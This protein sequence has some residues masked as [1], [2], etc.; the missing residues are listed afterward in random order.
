VTAAGLPLGFG[1]DLDADAKWLDES[2]LFA[3]SP[4]RVLRFSSAGR[5]VAAELMS[6]PVCTP[7]AAS[8][9]RRLTDAGAAHPQPP[10]PAV[11]PDVTVLIPVRDRIPELRRCLA[12]LGRHYPVLVVD[13]GSRDPAAVARV[14]AGH[15]ADLVRHVRNQGPAAARNTGLARIRTEFVA[16]L[17]SDCVAPHGWIEALAAQLADP[18][19]AAAAPR[20]RAIAPPTTSGRYTAACGALD[21]GARPARVAPL[22]RVSYVPTAALLVRRAALVDSTST[23]APFDVQL[24]YGEDV[25][26]VW[27]LHDTGWRVRYDPTVEVGHAEPDS[28]SAL[29]RRRFRYGTSAGALARRHPAAM[30]PLVLAVAGFVASVLTTRRTLRRAGVP[31][32]GTGSA[33][34]DAVRQTWLGVAR[35]GTQF[36][37]PVLAAAAVLPGRTDRRLVA[38]ALLLSPGV[39]AWRARRPDLDLPR[40][41]LASLADD[42][43]YGAG[44]WCGCVSNRT[45]VPVRPILSRPLLRPSRVPAPEPVRPQPSRSRS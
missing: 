12:A 35:Y 10:Q 11:A 34:A 28:W 14:V 38:A 21:L 43:A 45:A 29:L 33:T 42:I 37:A 40:F 7:A 27:R 18:L 17:D 22:T 5:R 2:T 39:A 26:L 3:G 32:G 9:A 44:V 13:D 8:L 30:P 23:G 31:V 25:D 19:V 6:G 1:I 41:L 20:I 36:A 24:R 15:G 4:A 16:L